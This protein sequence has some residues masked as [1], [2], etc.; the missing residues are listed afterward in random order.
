M[1][2]DNIG[3]EGA[4][5]LADALRVNASL[6]LLNLGGNKVGDDGATAIAQAVKSNTTCK[7]AELVLYDNGIGT[8]GAEALADMLSVSAPLT[9]CNVLSN[10]L[11]MQSATELSNIAKTKGISLS[12]ITPDQT[13]VDFSRR[14]LK[15]H[16]AVLVASDLS[17]E[18]VSAPL[19]L[20]NLQYNGLGDEGER[21]LH[22][23]NTRRGK[24]AELKM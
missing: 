24:P 3:A 16:D 12:G 11:D 8:A 7:L 9:V 6:T 22:Q 5:A 23:A 15:P 10:A 20:L 13:E 1:E 19:T 4:K 21:I 18:S 17:Q 14:G 2:R